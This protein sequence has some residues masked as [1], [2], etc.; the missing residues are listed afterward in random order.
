MALNDLLDSL[1]RRAEAETRA[2]LAAARAEAERIMEA[3]RR[4]AE[5]KRRER[6]AEAEASIRAS[7]E[8]DL[9]EARRSARTR[10][11][12]VRRLLLDRI[13]TRAHA[14]VQSALGEEAYRA[15]LRSGVAEALRYIDG[16]VVLECD[17][18]VESG[19]AAALQELGIGKREVSVRSA[20]ESTGGFR[21]LSTD[22]RVIVDATLGDR[23]DRM[24]PDLT[25][26]LLRHVETEGDPP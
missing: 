3:A 2:R 23:L 16:P 26:E 11:L 19:V 8:K 20:P 22:E 14:R 24:R 10:T 4:E 13:L 15:R 1:E 5:G 7:L 18:A 21:A 17:V 25:I 6:L 9:L 12:E